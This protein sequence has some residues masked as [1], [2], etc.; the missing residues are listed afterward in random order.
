MEGPDIGTFYPRYRLMVFGEPNHWVMNMGEIM[1]FPQLQ[2][3]IVNIGKE[4]EVYV[5]VTGPDR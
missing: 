2:D 3:L 5:W 4:G 1:G